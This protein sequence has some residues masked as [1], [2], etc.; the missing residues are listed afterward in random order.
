M[1]DQPENGP[2]NLLPVITLVIIAVLLLAGW[3][4]F[5]KLQRAIHV[6]DCVASGRTDCVQN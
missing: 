4:L 2:S 1:P 3:L 5:P 6:T